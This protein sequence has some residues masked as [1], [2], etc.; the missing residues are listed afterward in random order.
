MKLW[1]SL[2]VEQMLMPVSIV[3]PQ[4]RAG[5]NTGPPS[6]GSLEQVLSQSQS[7]YRSLQQVPLPDSVIVPLSWQVS[8]SVQV[9]LGNVFIRAAPSKHTVVVAK[10]LVWASKCSTVNAREGGLTGEQGK[11]VGG[12]AP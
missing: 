9:T 11:A 4:S 3:V 2:S 5:S 6:Y 8:L 7:L 10:C 1:V 12:N